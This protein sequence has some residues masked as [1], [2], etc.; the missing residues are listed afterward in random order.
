MFQGILGAE[1]CENKE[2]KA[3]FQ[4]FNLGVCI[5]RMNSLTKGYDLQ[6]MYLKMPT[7]LETIRYRRSI[8]GDLMNESLRNAFA[9]GL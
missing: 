7:R 8:T 3:I 2:K 1:I 5:S 6:E 4:D 9:Y